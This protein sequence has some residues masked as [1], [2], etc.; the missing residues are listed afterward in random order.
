MYCKNPSELVNLYSQYN[1]NCEGI[2]SDMAKMMIWLSRE[3]YVNSLMEK[4]QKE[5]MGQE[6]DEDYDEEEHWSRYEP[7]I[8][9][10][11]NE[12]MNFQEL[13]MWLVVDTTE[14]ILKYIINTMDSFFM[15]RYTSESS[16]SKRVRYLR[17]TEEDI[18]SYLN[19]TMPKNLMNP[20]FLPSSSRSSKSSSRSSKSS[21]RSSKE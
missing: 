16:A 13:F 10:F 19:E 1:P 18:L 6:E 9:A 12:T 3:G 7:I 5:K 14:R 21:S 20:I 17:I 15:D 8:E 11:E 4:Y 2:S